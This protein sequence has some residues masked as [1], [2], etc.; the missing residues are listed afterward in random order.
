MLKPFCRSVIALMS[1][2]VLAGCSGDG[3]VGPPHSPATAGRLNAVSANIGPSEIVFCIDVSDSISGGE[4]ESIVNGVGGCVSEQT[5]IPQ[6]GRVTVSV[7]VYADTTA[8]VLDRTPV[9]PENLQNA[10]LPAMQGLLT[11]RVVPTNGFDLSGALD[12]ALTILGSAAAND[13]HVLVIGSGAAD[14]PTTVGNACA[15]LANAGVMVSALAVGADEAGAALLKSCADATGGFL[16]SDVVCADALAY[17]LQ[18]DID[19][20]PE[21]AELA[22]GQEHTVT[23]TVFRGGDPEA[24]PEAGIEVVIAVVEGPNASVAD[25][26]ATDAQG[27]VKLTYAGVGGP[28]TDIIVGEVAHPGTGVTLTDTVTVTWLNAPPTCDAGGPY[29]VVITAD[30]ASV[31]LDAGASSDADGDPLSFRWSVLC[32]SGAWFDDEHAVSPVL[33]LTGDCLCVDSVMVELVVSDGFDSTLCEAAVRIDDRRPP[34]I[35]MREDPLL[36]WPPNHKYQTVTPQMMIISAEDACG[37]PIDVSSA[38]VVEVRSDEP[39]DTNG[40]GHT[41]DDIRVTCPNTV[42][43]RAERMGGGNGRVYTIVYRIVAD[44]GVGAEAVG[45]VFVPHDSS[46]KTVIEDP[47]GGFVVR[48]ECGQD[49]LTGR[50]AR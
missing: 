26:M 39:D 7:V 16:G 43:L 10:I 31:T 32:E 17:M 27:M 38:A 22:R 34:T 2:A 42:D 45:H 13:R 30:T 37:V 23:A 49:G 9:T 35:V 12:N 46:G 3:S 1:L 11:N 8:T 50:M 41:T 29:T 4:L 47:D 40:D 44:N 25:T 6:D 19:L 20:E 18:V 15:A 36:F 33:T 5:L 48:P 14:D 21:S 24:Y 28:G